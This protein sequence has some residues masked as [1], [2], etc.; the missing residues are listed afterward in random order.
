MIRY[1]WSRSFSR[2]D[3]IEEK[4]PELKSILANR[5]GLLPPCEMT[6][7]LHGII[8]VADQIERIGPPRSSSM[9]L[10]ERGNKKLKG[11]IM[12]HSAPISS[13]V[14]NYLI[15]EL[16]VFSSGLHFGHLKNLEDLFELVDPVIASR[17][18]TGLKGLDS[19]V[20]DEQTDRLSVDPSFFAKDADCQSEEAPPRSSN[21]S[22]Q[23]VL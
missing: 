3:L 19:L 18:T 21:F 10:F 9:Y 22:L 11:L 2:T 16:S 1:L 7:A 15:S 6:Y 20:Y 14:K 4:I 23:K 5:E 17:L 12:N 8:H 13:L